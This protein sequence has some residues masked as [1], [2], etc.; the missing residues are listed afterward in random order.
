MQFLSP[1]R[2]WLLALLPLLLALYLWLLGARKHA[3]IRYPS[4]A[5]IREATGSLGWRR[6]A[7]PLLLLAAVALLLLAGARPVATLTLPSGQKTVIL[8]MDVSGS[9]RATDVEPS[10]LQASQVAAVRFVRSLPR[11]V[12]VGVVAFGGEAH[13]V[14]R[15]TL[16]R[17]DVL[18][19]IDS[20]QFQRATAIG[21]A[22]VVS[23]AAIFPDED[24][25]VHASQGGSSPQRANRLWSSGER[26]TSGS[27]QLAPGS[28][29]STAIIVLT[30][31]QKTTGVDPMAAARMA[32]ARGVK[33]FTVGFGTK[34]GDTISIEG[35]RMHVRLDE[36]TLRRVADI[37]LG[38]Y[39]HAGSTTDLHSVYNALN[40]RLVLERQE[41]EVSS[42][43]AQAAALLVLVAVGLSVRWY[44]RIA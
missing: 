10:R 1:E 23:L 12:R 6:H 41:A 42:L 35:W 22:I 33:V 4:L 11:T 3:A 8:A 16:S 40:A 20:L 36:E 38:E 26:R 31:G 15:P 24:I 30:D 14:Q 27:E 39:F 18:A 17:G 37:T 28:Y 19:A 44:G 5:A 32:A 43:F 13:L 25:D 29:T 34:D 9:M 7:P 2:L 21:S